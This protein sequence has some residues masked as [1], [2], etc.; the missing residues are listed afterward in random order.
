VRT[1]ETSLDGDGNGRRRRRLISRPL[2]DCSWPRRPKSLTDRDLR[3]NFPGCSGQVAEWLKAPVSK[4]G[5][6][7]NPVSRVR[8]SPCPFSSGAPGPTCVLGC[9][10]SPP[11]F[12][13]EAASQRPALLGVYDAHSGDPNQGATVRDTRLRDALRRGIGLQSNSSACRRT[14]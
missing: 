14:T 13:R 8:I 6:P 7:V 9:R 4:T 2:A 12:S 10:Q 5:I 1:K 3:P 11:R